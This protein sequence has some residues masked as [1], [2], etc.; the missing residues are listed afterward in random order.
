MM[1]SLGPG[2]VGQVCKLQS[3][4]G[5]STDVMWPDDVGFPGLLSL[6]LHNLNR[7][8]EQQLLF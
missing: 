7:I 1:A 5:N 4:W 6:T 2:L 8:I 3:V